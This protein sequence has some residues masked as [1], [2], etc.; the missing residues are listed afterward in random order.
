MDIRCSGEVYKD[1]ISTQTCLDCA[2]SRGAPPCGFDYA[3]LKAIF[4]NTLSEDRS[5]VHVTDLTGCLLRAYWD[6]TDPQPKYVHDL[7][8]LWIGQAVHKSVE[9]AIRDDP[10][11]QGEVELEMD[12]VKGRADLIYGD[13]IVD[14]KTTRWMMP[15]RLPYG[16][17]SD[18]VKIYAE[19]A[20]VENTRIQYIDTTGPTRCNN[21]KTVLVK[22]DG[23]PVCE[24]C[25]W[26]KGAAHLGAHIVKPRS[27][28]MK[29]FIKERGAR[30]TDALESEQEPEA[31]PSWL[32]RY[33]DHLDKCPA[34][35][36]V[37]RR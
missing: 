33:C 5:D 10:N 31:E 32:C 30:L 8:V 29:D 36:A 2:L 7:V 28:D 12:G 18:Q 15:G 37:V 24:N 16:N 26:T 25:G 4:A 19:M 22:V 20:G 9:E 3:V 11:V 34:G 23:H 21:C 14:L 13:T 17:H 6:K 27:K 1:P 35:R